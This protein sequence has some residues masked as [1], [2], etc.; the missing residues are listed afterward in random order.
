MQNSIKAALS[1][2]AALMAV[3]AAPANAATYQY[4]Y[5]F[6]TGDTATGFFTGTG[7]ITDITNISNVS[8]KI[9]GA[10]IAGVAAYMYTG[11]MGPSGPNCDSCYTASGAVVSS[12]PLAEN[13]LFDNGSEYF[14]II[15]WNN[16]AGNQV[17]TQAVGPNGVIDYY[18][19]QYIPANFSVTAV[20]EASTWALMLAGFG[21]AGASLRRRSRALAA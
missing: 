11:Y 20:P 21:L 17:A 1:G 3:A 13:F 10:P 16:G 14:Y 18:N 15:P 19:G 12:N 7:P 4:A 2:A 6:D 5:T 8:L 9:D